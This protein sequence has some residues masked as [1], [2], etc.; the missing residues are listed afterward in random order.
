MIGLPPGN[1]LQ[2][3]YL[4]ERLEV[5]KSQGLKSFIEIGSGNGNVSKIFLDKGFTGT[6]FDLNESACENNKV[7]NI[8]CIKKGDYNVFNE[9]FILKELD[10]KVDIIISCM[11]IE[12]M[13][14][15]VLNDYFLKCKEVLNE[16]GI[17][18]TLVP[19]SMDYWGIEDEIA[20]H[21]KRYEFEDIKQLSKK[22]DLSINNLAGLT[23]PISNIVFGIS[24]KLIKSNESGKLKLSQK[25]KTIYTGNRNVK[26]KTTFPKVFNI[27]LNPFIL[28]PFH[29]LQKIFKKN[30]NNM[31][32]YGELKKNKL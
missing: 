2:Y 23:Y 17:I 3:I 4:K 27:I 26:Y 31:V 29:I 12:H 10:S 9:D 13:P 15:E 19:S 20:G 22:Y 25:E 16:N 28:Y 11:V 14:A 8:D 24:N 30:K 1:I 6:G 7:R 18:I 5:L 32:I 21:I